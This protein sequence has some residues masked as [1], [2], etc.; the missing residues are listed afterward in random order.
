LY[1]TSNGFVVPKRTAGSSTIH[2]YN[3]V[4]GVT[5]MTSGI[6]YS[7][8]LCQTI[9]DEEENDEEQHANEEVELG[10]NLKEQV[11]NEFD[12]FESA[13]ALL[14]GMDDEEM[15]SFVEQYQTW[16]ESSSSSSSSSPYPSLA[17]EIVS[18][19][20]MIR[21][22]VF[23]EASSIKRVVDLQSLVQDVRKQLVFFMKILHEKYQCET[24][25]L[26]ENS[27]SEYISFLRLAGSTCVTASEQRIEPSLIVDLVWHVH[28]QLFRGSVYCADSI[29][30]GGR[31]VDHNF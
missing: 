13:V 26:I 23:A 21:P 30:I 2:N 31:I 25:I 10:T 8:F 18:K 20:H 16:F 12:F 27:V 1:A 22:I 11:L 29:R 14:K 4:H 19:V 5:S 15:L 24:S 3:S 28:M 7:L 9:T 6:R 17:V